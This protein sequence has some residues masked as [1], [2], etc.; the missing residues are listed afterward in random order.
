VFEDSQTRALERDLIN[1]NLQLNLYLSAGL[2]PDKALKEVAKDSMG[3]DKPLERV[4]VYCKS[5]S[6]SKNIP[7]DAALSDVAGKIKSRNLLRFAGIITDNRLRGSDLSEKLERERSLMQ[8]DRLSTARALAKEA[9][10]KLSLPLSLLLVVLIGI[11]IA[12]AV[13]SM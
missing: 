9:E 2:V 12:P 5:M 4:L 7:M 13:L 8:S 3:I 11:C 6:D 10:T 1:L